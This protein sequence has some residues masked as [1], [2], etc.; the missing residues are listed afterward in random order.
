MSD[1]KLSIFTER[2]LPD[3]IRHD[4]PQFLLFIKYWFEHIESD[5]EVYD[6]TANARDYMAIDTTKTLFF[7]DFK[8]TYLVGFPDGTI[9]DV[10]FIVKHIRDFYQSK[11]TENS[12]KFL[13]HFLYN[14]DITFYYPKT[15]ILR[16]SDGKWDE[17]SQTW[18]NTDG[19][20]SWDKKL[21]DNYYY[22]D[23]SYEIVSDISRYYYERVLGT[24]IHPAGSLMFGRTILFDDQ[25]HSAY[26]LDY[27]TYDDLTTDVDPNVGYGLKTWW[28]TPRTVAD[29][30]LNSHSLLIDVAGVVVEELVEYPYIF[31][32][33]TYT[34]G[35]IAT[36]RRLGH[37]QGSNE[38][39]VGTGA[40]T[41]FNLDDVYTTV[42]VFVNGIKQYETIDYNITD[43]TTYVSVDF[44][45]A[46]TNSADILVMKQD[47]VSQ[48]LISG[49]GT[50][51]TITLTNHPQGYL[52]DKVLISIDGNIVTP[53]SYNATTKKM[54]FDFVVSEGTNNIEVLHMPDLR[55][56]ETI[57]IEDGLTKYNIDF[58]MNEFKHAPE[59]VY[60]IVFT[61][62]DTI[63]PKLTE[64]TTVLNSYISQTDDVLLYLSE[65]PVYNSFLG[66]TDTVRPK[67]VEVPNPI[68]NIKTGSPDTLLPKITEGSTALFGTADVQDWLRPKIT[69][70]TT[71]MFKQIAT[72]DT[73]LPKISESDASVSAT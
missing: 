42:L 36:I 54:T 48:E 14:E 67:L 10:R 32:L 26:G 62:S 51:K 59:A 17:T 5:D 19:W 70:G 60:T 29:E 27:T 65:I 18:S 69:E 4:H 50:L 7:D 25:I 52:K 43:H 64:G 22:Q 58:N 38:S 47:Y 41:Q 55:T 9:T 37:A 30:E 24:T 34:T 63:R 45:S 72:S 39:F 6:F 57:V 61:P 35:D 8:K 23:F 49:L 1:K 44:V 12:F 20:L 11:G 28:G 15:D 46:P 21:Q 13:F 71:L 31:P 73:L 2:M 66:G 68:N 16:C 33:G 53:L 40:Q 56:T 3:Y